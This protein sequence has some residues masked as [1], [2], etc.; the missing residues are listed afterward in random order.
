MKKFLG[1]AAFVVAA[2]FVAAP[3]PA[4]AQYIG[5]GK[6][7]GLGP[8]A[9]VIGGGGYSPYGWPKSPYFYRRDWRPVYV[10]PITQV[11]Y[12]YPSTTYV[13]QEQAVDANTGTIRM[14]VPSDARVWIEGTAS[15]QTG[16]DRSFVSPPLTPGR[17]YVYHIRVQWDENGKAVER[18]REVKMH[19]GD[20]I[21]LNIDR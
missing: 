18:D 12:Y 1:L 14:H 21:S 15:S 10:Y 7:Y 3:T 11:S 6:Y 9:L 17:E 16:A 4:A 8:R 2:L 20:R 5:F 19:A 13:P